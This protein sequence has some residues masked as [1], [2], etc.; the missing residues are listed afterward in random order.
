MTLTASKGT[1]LPAGPSPGGNWTWS[2]NAILGDPPIVGEYVYITATDSDGRKDQCVFRLQ[3]GGT[4]LGSDTGDPH[5]RTV[6]GTSYDFQSA[7]EFVLLRDR[8]GM[9]VQV[10]QTPAE[11][12]PPITDDYSGL[13]A[14]V[15]L[16][17]AVA[18]RVGSHRV[19]YQHFRDRRTSSSSWTE[20]SAAPKE[21]LD[22][23]GIASPRSTPAENRGRIDYAHGLSSP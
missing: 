9:E 14:C 4:D 15:S 3:V 20:T 23:M 2:Y 6:D 11:T 22:L 8:D 12:P 5:I 10:R 16:N 18:A 1:V 17:S 7:G 19:S 21:G 13:K